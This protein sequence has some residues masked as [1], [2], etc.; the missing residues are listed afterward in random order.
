LVRIIHSLIPALL[1]D[2]S[3]A[4]TSSSGFS[5]HFKLVTIFFIFSSVHDKTI[6]SLADILFHLVIANLRGHFGEDIATT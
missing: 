1:G 4:K 5:F 2:N 3:S 6:V